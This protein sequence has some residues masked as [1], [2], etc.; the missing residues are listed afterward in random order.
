MNDKQPQ[1]NNETLKRM[2]RP[3]IGITREMLKALRVAMPD[4]AIRTT[5]IVGFPG[6]TEACFRELLDFIRDTKFER[7]G[8]FAFSNEPETPAHVLDGHLTEDVKSGRRERL[9]AAQQEIAFAQPSF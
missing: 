2:K 1:Q 3:N 9:M 5:F 6:E 4:L 7:L 8:V